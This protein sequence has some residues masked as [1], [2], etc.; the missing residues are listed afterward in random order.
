ME[1]NNPDE[2]HLSWQIQMLGR[3]KRE[4]IT[5]INFCQALCDRQRHNLTRSALLKVTGDGGA[6]QKPLTGL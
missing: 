2:Y 6:Y 5:E 4:V 3:C 1:V